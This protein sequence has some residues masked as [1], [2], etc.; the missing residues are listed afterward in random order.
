[1]M[2]DPSGHIRLDR[3]SPKPLEAQIAAQLMQMIAADMIGVGESLP[4]MRSLAEAIGVNLH[5]VRAAYH[6][7]ES[8]GLVD[9]TRRRGTRVVARDL[10]GF[11]QDDQERS[12]TIGVLFPAVS[13]FYAPVVAGM[14]SVLDGEPSGLLF[15]FANERRDS[16]LDS[17]R[18]F[19]AAGVDGI[20]VVSQ[21]FDEGVVFDDAR[22]PPVVFGDWPGAPGYSV[23]FDP[24]TFGDLVDHFVGHGHSSIGLICPPSRHPNIAP[25]VDAYARACLRLGLS[26]SAKAVYE[27]PGWSAS[28]GETAA[29][30]ALESDH[31]PT[32]L[33]AATDE[34]AVGVYRAAAQLGMRVGVDLAVAGH[35]GM[36]LGR[37]VEPT[38]TTVGLPAEEMGRRLMTML[39]ELID[40][41]PV[42]AD[43]QI[44]SRLVLR[45]SCGR[46][47]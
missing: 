9:V 10:A 5:T 35:G 38:L 46:H 16:A 42:A 34:L 2:I 43:L 33:L 8:K 41:Q 22:M 26:G 19:L 12:F 30:L 14:T 18:R 39:V 28:H 7:L 11:A 25:L 37:F 13:S 27:V 21:T 1:M 47:D 20:A 36:D 40:G 44:P 24:A 29:R 45:G 4:S 32:A 3:S 31:R 23:T 6:R 15:A 17:L